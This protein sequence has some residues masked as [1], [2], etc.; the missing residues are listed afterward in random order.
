MA[1]SSIPAAIDGIITLLKAAPGLRG[2]EVMD[3]AP[4]VNTPNDFVAVA[5]SED[6]GDV[7]SGYQGILAMGNLLRDESYDISCRV[8]SWI[9]GTEMKKVR[10]RAFDLF[11]AIETT[12]QGAMTLDGAVTFAQ[13]APVSFAQYQTDQGATA[14]LDFA[15]SVRAARF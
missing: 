9:G 14:D 5:F 13:I 15:V 1:T 7:V 11:A 8:S 12:L 2:V 3:G 4:T 10:D 6:G